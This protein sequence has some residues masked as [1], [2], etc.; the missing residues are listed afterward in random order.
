[1]PLLCVG[2]PQRSIF[3]GADFGS[4]TTLYLQQKLKTVYGKKSFLSKESDTLRSYRVYIYFTYDVGIMIISSYL[5]R[6]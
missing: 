3:F 4:T 2:P 1:M 5:N 6:N